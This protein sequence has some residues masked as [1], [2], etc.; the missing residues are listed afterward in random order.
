MTNVCNGP[1]FP[2][3]EE[4]M[5]IPSN[6]PSVVCAKCSYINPPQTRICKGCGA[7]FGGY[8][9]IGHSVNDLS[10]KY[11]LFQESTKNATNRKLILWGAGLAGLSFILLVMVWIASQNVNLGT[12][13]SGEGNTTQKGGPT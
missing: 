6:G 5:T 2:R 9:S 12:Q 8:A 3:T 4:S 10:H 1:P 11:P 7:E 13:R